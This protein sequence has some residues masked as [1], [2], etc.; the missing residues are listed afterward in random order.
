MNIMIFSIC[1]WRKTLIIFQVRDKRK[2]IGYYPIS[3]G[4]GRVFYKQI[5]LSL[6]IEIGFKDFFD[7]ERGNLIMLTGE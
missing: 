1:D 2:S 3:S 7:R 4:I 5:I 6:E